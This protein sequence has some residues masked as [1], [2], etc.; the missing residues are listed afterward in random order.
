MTYELWKYE[1]Y[2]S[3]FKIWNTESTESPQCSANFHNWPGGAPNPAR[4]LILAR[5]YTALIEARPAKARS[6]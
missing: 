6:K 4:C 2:F 5:I 1:S 3:L